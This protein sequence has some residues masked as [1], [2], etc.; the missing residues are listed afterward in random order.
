MIAAATMAG[1]SF[2]EWTQQS[3][4]ACQPPVTLCPR[5]KQSKIKV[6]KIKNS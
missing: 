6:T 4:V 3:I 5:S 2:L 1:L